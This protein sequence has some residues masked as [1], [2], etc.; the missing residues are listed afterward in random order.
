MKSTKNTLEIIHFSLNGLKDLNVQLYEDIHALS[1]ES[2]SLFIGFQKVTQP[3]RLL[4]EASAETTTDTTS[5]TTTEATASTTVVDPTP[6]PTPTPV[7]PDS[8]MPLR[9]QPYVMT[10][11]LFS[12]L[13]LFVA[14]LGSIALCSVQ[15]PDKFPRL[16][17]LVG[18]ESN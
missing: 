14:L 9:I 12:L 17:L 15:A 2:Y 16:P 7:N 1:H 10:G 3:S 11:Y 13:A 8:L 18:R 5:V 4:Q 6:T